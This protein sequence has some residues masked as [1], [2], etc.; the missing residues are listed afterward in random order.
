[1]TNPTLWNSWK[2][3][4]IS[5]LYSATLHQLENRAPAALTQHRRIRQA[6]HNALPQLQ[7]QGVDEKSVRQLWQRLPADYFLRHRDELIIWHSLQILQSRE[8]PLV[9]F[10]GKRKRGGDELF[11]YTH[12]KPALFSR[13]VTALDRKKISVHDAQI[14]TSKDGFTLDTFVLLNESNQPIAANRHSS[15]I[16]AVK[17]ELAQTQLASPNFLSIA[18]LAPFNFNAR[19]HFSRSSS[20]KQTV[21]ELVALD[22]PGL[23]ARIGAVFAAQKIVLR[24]ARISTVGERA[25]NQF[26]LANEQ[27]QALSNLDKQQFKS[28]LLTAI[29]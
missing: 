13:I 21:L 15:I 14:I 5:E 9:V 18:K 4:L 27:R 2:K 10:N 22:T 20:S 23:L 25:E 11:V 29:S 24:S 26:V 17:K 19:V 12:D 1:A 6:Q 8:L 28:A 16:Q 7:K 3:A